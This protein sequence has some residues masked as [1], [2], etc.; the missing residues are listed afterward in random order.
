MLKTL[1]GSPQP[2][3][4]NGKISVSE[5][6]DSLHHIV[7]ILCSCVVPNCLLNS[8]KHAGI[9]RRIGQFGVES[10]EEPLIFDGS[11]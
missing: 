8:K 4:E 9:T 10:R 5:S 2:V 6:T 11:V 3:E 7:I 1:Q